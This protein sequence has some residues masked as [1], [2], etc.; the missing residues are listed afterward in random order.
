MFAITIVHVGVVK[1][2]VLAKANISLRNRVSRSGGVGVMTRRHISSDHLLLFIVN[3]IF[4]YCYISL[5]TT[6][7]PGEIKIFLKTLF[8][9]MFK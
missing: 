6:E 3:L 9:K 1:E 7:L 2:L 5:F 8:K 4:H